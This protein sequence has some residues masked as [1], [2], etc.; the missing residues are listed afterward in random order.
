MN[1]KSITL[2]ALVITLGTPGLANARPGHG[3]RHAQPS[4]EDFDKDSNGAI[5][6]AEIALF[7]AEKFTQ[8]DTNADGF[9]ELSELIARMN[10]GKDDTH[11]GHFAKRMEHKMEHMISRADTDNDGMLSQDEAAARGQGKM[12]ERL[13]TD[14]N[15]A[16]SQEEWQTRSD[17]HH[18]KDHRDD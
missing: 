4:F 18:G 9:L 11:R 3:M 10:D 8:T 15:G 17:N 1:L 12:F 14:E 16:I 7:H 5:T 13:D 6:Q 2:A